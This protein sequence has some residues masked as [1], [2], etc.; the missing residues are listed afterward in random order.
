MTDQPASKVDKPRKV[1]RRGN[2]ALKACENCRRMKTRCILSPLPNEHQCLRCDTLKLRCSFQDLWEAEDDKTNQSGSEAT[3]SQDK[4]N[5]NSSITSYESAEV[6]KRL[7][8]SGYSPEH[9]AVHSKLLQ[10]VNKNVSKILELLQSQRS[11]TDARENYLKSSEREV[12]TVHLAVEDAAPTLPPQVNGLDHLAASVLGLANSGAGS[13]D[14]NEST[15]KVEHRYS[16]PYLTCPFTM[17]TQMASR[18]N[19]PLSIRKL[20]ERAFMPQE[21]VA[22][23]IEMDLLTQDE[24][25]LLMES[26]RD[27]YGKWCSF[28]DSSSSHKL[29]EILR[30][31]NASLLLSTIC[32]LALRYTTQHHDLKTRIY[33]SLLYKLKTDV[34]SSL[35]MVPQ[36]VE[37]IQ[38][39]VLL[40]LYANSFSS[41]IM[42]VDAWY[43]SGIGLQQFLSVRT[44]EGQYGSENESTEF[45]E[46]VISSSLDSSD[47][48]TGDSGSQFRKLQLYRLWNHL[49]LAHIAN[50]VFSGRMCIIDGIRADLCRRTLDFPKSTNF[51]GRMVAEISLQLILYNFVQQCTLSSSKDHTSSAAY[52]AVNEELRIW[53]EEWGYLLT[54]PIY[55]SKQYAEFALDYSHAIVLYTWFHRSYRGN[56]SNTSGVN[57]LRSNQRNIPASAISNQS[58]LLEN[59]NREFSIPDIVSSMPIDVQFMILKH[60]HKA[61]EAMISGHFESFRFLSDQLIFQCVHASLMCLIVARNLYYVEN[62]LL[63]EEQLEQ[64]LSDVKKFSLRLHK[65]RQGELKSFWV[66]EVDLKIPSVILQ[67][68]KSIEACLQDSFPEYQIQVSDDYL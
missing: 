27:G 19:V 33:K 53:N 8:K 25:V 62:S 37:F 31:R 39:I 59:L 50:C 26:F 47:S 4:N 7:L 54:Q 34:D 17:I 13:P 32:V 2:R 43:M 18:E 29:V 41:D 1:K 61:I 60:T 48:A 36:T 58:P 24:V 28:P 3:D 10:N 35:Q 49:C 45:S 9:F 11:T 14:F 38:A 51:D 30:A 65:V 6:T 46:S 44:S 67:Y 40:S 21:L 64:V 12:Q 52:E 5:N 66:E 16:T 15:I 56:R 57:G 55:P 20:Y 42:A 63:K 22:D 23:V 68:H